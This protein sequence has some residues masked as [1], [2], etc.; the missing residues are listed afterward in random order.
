[1]IFYNLQTGSI[2]EFLTALAAV[3]TVMFLWKYRKSEEVRYL[4]FL[5][6][7][8]A[9]WALT[10]GFEFATNNLELKIFWSKMS[11]LGIAFAPLTY[12]LFTTSFSQKEN[13]INPRNVALLSILPFITLVMVF[14]NDYH[15]LVWT[16]VTMHPEKNMAIYYHGTWFW[17]YFGYSQLLIFSGLFNLISS[18][19]KFSSFYRSQVGTLLIASFIPII[20]NLMYITRINPI[21]GFDWTPLTFVFTGITVA[22]GVIRYRMFDLVPNAKNKLIDSMDDGVVVV[23]AD[24][25]VE[26][27][28]PVMFQILESDKKSIVLQSIEN[29]FSKSPGL[30]KSVRE[31]RKQSLY[32][33]L[34]VNFVKRFYHITINPIF[35]HRNKFSGS[36]LLFH[37]IT[38]LK[39][40]EKKLKKTNTR[41]KT[42]MGKK[43]KL[44][45]SLDS[46]A[47]TVAHD[48]KSLLGSIYSSSEVMEEAVQQEDKKLQVEL[49]EMIKNSAEKTIKI[50]QEL[51]LLATTSQ[52]S[53]EKQTVNMKNSFAEAKNQLKELIE[54]DNAT[55]AEPD[56]WPDAKGH[57]Q[58]IE[59]VWVNYLSN[60]IKYGGNPS[61]ISV[62]AEKIEGEKIKFWV[63]DNGD[64]I[65][66]SEHAKLFKKYVR[67]DPEKAD[68]YGLGLS[69]VKQI[70]DKLDGTVGV[71]STGKKG[72]GALFYFT[73][74]SA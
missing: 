51:L 8:I 57:P 68:G 55:I 62:G 14:T 30:I 15:N 61:E 41:L 44:I 28:N 25:F 11:Y 59:D 10:Y 52:E 45:E 71:E 43:E 32:L 33:D 4:I 31:K 22:F 3:L 47:H 9:I 66:K 37:D 5:E 1:M 27:C 29:V 70:L 26:D 54:N 16:E 48:L 2:I 49:M 24:G 6:I 58:W 69:I 35:N 13:I 34:P 63:K 17:I 46:F 40:A 18:I 21:P 23:N 12:F 56:E 67:L 50:T 60:A 39:S 53:I 74:P 20:G 73:L 42:E 19:Y 7:L 65:P 36:F 72:E 38:A 64:G